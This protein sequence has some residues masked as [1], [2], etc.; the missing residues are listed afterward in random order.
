MP[1]LKPGRKKG[2]PRLK[3]TALGEVLA[4]N[5]AAE[6]ERQ[7]GREAAAAL[8]FEALE[9]AVRR[10]ALRSA[11]RVVK[12]RLNADPSD[13]TGGRRPCS[14]G[15]P[16]RYVDRHA[17]PFQTDLGELRL[18]RGSARCRRPAPA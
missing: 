14:C 10:Q 5:L 3:E 4:H 2:K 11:A 7:M 6:I 1:C 9:T 15:Q 18:E 13:F 17:K 12:Q 8:D 16:A